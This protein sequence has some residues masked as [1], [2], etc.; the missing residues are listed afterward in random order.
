M[1]ELPLE[2]NSCD[3]VLSMNG[4]HAFPDKNQAFQEIWRVVKPGGKFI[5]CFY[6]KGK[7]KITDWLVKNILSKEGWL[8]WLIVNIRNIVKGV[9]CLKNS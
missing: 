9:I 6:I 8:L 2:V 3:I 7:S 1:G 4:F 5:A